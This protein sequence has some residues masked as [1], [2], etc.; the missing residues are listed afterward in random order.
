MITKFSITRPLKNILKIINEAILPKQQVLGRWNSVIEQK[1]NKNN[2][3]YKLLYSDYA[4][5]D[6]SI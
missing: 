3:N 4:N 5:K 6:H 1:N 2:N